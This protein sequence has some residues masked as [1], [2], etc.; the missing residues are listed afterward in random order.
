M[1]AP[2]AHPTRRERFKDVRADIADLVM[3]LGDGNDDGARLD[4]I[5]GIRARLW[6]EGLDLIDLADRVFGSTT[7]QPGERLN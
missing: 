4:A 7:R 1:T 6:A 3:K 5:A 2:L